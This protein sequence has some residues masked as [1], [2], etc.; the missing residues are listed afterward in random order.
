MAFDEGLGDRV[1]DA[2]APRRDVEEK[3]MFGGICFMVA[4][5]MTVGVDKDRKKR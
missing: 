4:G 5:H 2:L 3:R 1:R